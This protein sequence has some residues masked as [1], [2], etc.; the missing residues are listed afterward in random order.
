MNQSVVL[1][2]N[3]KLMQ[4]KFFV[5]YVC[6]LISNIIIIFHSVGMV[7]TTVNSKRRVT[8]ILKV[9]VIIFGFSNA[10]QL[11]LVRSIAIDTKTSLQTIDNEKCLSNLS[12]SQYAFHSYNN[13]SISLMYIH[14]CVD[15]KENP[16]TFSFHIMPI[17]QTISQQ[18]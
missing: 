8:Y 12:Y 11:F 5:T 15:L 1:G 13:H 18:S 10:R 14:L 16:I 6:V 9:I 7:E 2:F 4:F 3:P 17:Q